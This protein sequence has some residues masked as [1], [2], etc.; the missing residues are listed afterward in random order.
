MQWYD[1]FQHIEWYHNQNE[2]SLKF[3]HYNQIWCNCMVQ[4]IVIVLIPFIPI[5]RQTKTV[6]SMPYIPI[7]LS[8]KDWYNL[9]KN[10]YHCMYSLSILSIDIVISGSREMTYFYFDTT[11]VCQLQFIHHDIFS[12]FLNNHSGFPLLYNKIHF[13]SA[14]NSSV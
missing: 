3:I 10:F 2:T 12:D 8:R 9:K 11:Q 13:C 1:I 6:K 7:N 4:V 14:F 5:I